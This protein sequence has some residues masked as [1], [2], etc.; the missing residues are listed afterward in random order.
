VSAVDRWSVARQRHKCD[1]C[2]RVIVQ[3]HRYRREA[4]FGD[5]DVYTWREHEECRAEAE[6]ALD[7]DTLR[8]GVPAGALSRAHG[9]TDDLSGAYV[10]WRDAQEVWRDAREG[11]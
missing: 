7:V 1:L 4:L 3:G 9:V 11:R 5:G 6:R 8:R 2:L 10:A